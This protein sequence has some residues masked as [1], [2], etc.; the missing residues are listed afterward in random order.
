MRRLT[1]LQATRNA[2]VE[3]ISENLR[4]NEKTKNKSRKQYVEQA[5]ELADIFI[6]LHQKGVHK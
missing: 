4:W 6:E 5:N 2:L 1:K 3:V